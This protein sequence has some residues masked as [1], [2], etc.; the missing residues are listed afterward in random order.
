MI[1]TLLYL[2]VCVLCVC[3]HACMLTSTL[4]DAHEDTMLVVIGV[5]THGCINIMLWT[6]R[7]SVH[8][9]IA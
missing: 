4:L 5:R 8:A 6:E 1:V 2:C 7:S 3:M 9:Y